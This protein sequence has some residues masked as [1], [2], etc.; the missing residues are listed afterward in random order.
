MTTTTANA[1]PVLAQ[2]D[3][4]LAAVWPELKV[5]VTSITEQWAAMAVS[6]PNS[7]PVLAAALEDIQMSN[8]AFPPTAVR[9]GP[10]AGVPVMVAPLSISRELAPE[11]YRGAPPPA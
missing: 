9:R 5:A 10:L 8:A 2:L 1:G 6:G 7:R 4:L 3:F 11:D